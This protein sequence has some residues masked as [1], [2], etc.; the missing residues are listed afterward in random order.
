MKQKL[1]LFVTIL[2]LTLVACD[3]TKT[4]TAEEIVAE[5][6]KANEFFEDAF[7]RQIALSPIYQSYLGMKENQDKWDDISEEGRKKHYELDKTL[8]EELK[9]INYDALDSQTKLSYDLAK[10]DTERSIEGHKYRFHGYPINQ[11]FGVHSRTPAFLINIHNISTLK[12]AED[13]LVRIDKMPIY[14]NQL[15]DGLKLREEKG[16]MPPKFV[17]PR[18]IDDSKNVIK[19]YPIT[20]DKKNNPI[21]DDFKSKVFKLDIADDTKKMLIK[22]LEGKL[23]NALKPA[24]ES[25]IIFLEDQV[26]RAT[27]DDGV[28]KLPDGENYYKFRLEGTTTTK[29]TPQ[30]I[31]DF[32]TIEVKRIHDEMREI[33][34][35][36]NFDGDLQAFFSFMRED[37]QFYYPNTDEGR[38][39][40]IT[41]AIALI[42]NMRDRLDELFI[43]KPKAKMIVKRVESFREQ[44]AATAF[45]N[46]P[47]PDGTR[48]GIYYANLYNMKNMPKYQMEALAYHEGIPGHH[49]Q[50]AIAQELEDIPKFRKFGGYTAF[51]EGWGLYCERIP[52]EMGLYEDPYSDF[53][54]LAMELWR[55]CR[56]VAD[57]GIHVKKWTREKAIKFYRENT[58][59]SAR[60]CERMVE[61]HIV[62]PSQATAYKVG[63]HK[64]LTLREHAKKQMG[65][66]F[67]IREFHNVVL[68]N[69]AVPMYVLADMIEDYINKSK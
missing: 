52:K 53:G 44:S 63:M 32:G 6:K 42:D 14:F 19:G 15:I 67:D 36:V 38:E 55:S 54:R 8:L 65:D 68:T 21:Y 22:S 12:D 31:F 35:K 18:V 34:K 26:T 27:T 62:M 16:V 61:R 25:L 50:I 7:Q 41:E 23:V 64:I 56:L 47:A 69:G 45:Y 58:P 11:M 51:S 3:K 2:A 33:M 46:R 17:F 28:W 1:L 39:T 49:M 20:N 59:D 57:V 37:E 43:V 9:K 24:Y 10:K 60:D 30:E 40:Y 29:M 66:K 48:P 5:S 13:Y 4:Y